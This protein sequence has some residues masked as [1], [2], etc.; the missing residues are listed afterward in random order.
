MTTTYKINEFLDEA[1]I[2]LFEKMKINN[3][4]RYKTAAL[5]E[6]GISEGLIYENF[7]EKW[8]DINEIKNM[9]N[10]KEG[11]KEKAVAFVLD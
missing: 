9:T 10:S 8:F 4:R 2:K 7:I 1:D 6:W 3:P 5:G 11:F